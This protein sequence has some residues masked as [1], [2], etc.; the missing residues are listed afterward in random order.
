MVATVVPAVLLSIVYQTGVV[1][2]WWLEL[3]QYVPFPAFLLSAI[4]AFGLSFRL[5][6]AWRLAAAI[7]L[8]LVLTV[9]MGGVAGHADRGSGHV[10][11][12]TYNIKAWLAEHRNGGFSPLVWEVALQDPDILVMQ[13]AAELTEMREQA[14][15]TA[16]PIFKRR[17][18]FAF[19][20]YIVVSRFPLRDCQVGQIPY[21][22]EPHTYVRCIVTAQGVDIDLVTVHF[23]SPR[24]GLNAT[25]F[26]R[27]DGVGEWQ[28][29]FNDRLSQSSRLAADI[30]RRRRPLILAGDL[31]APESSPVVRH[32]LERGLRD[33]FSSAGWGYGYTHGHALKLRFSFLRIDHILVSPDI[34]VQDSFVGGKAASEHRPVI[35]DLWLQRE[36]D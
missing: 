14:P 9:L 22:G 32:L 30:S 29:N 16:S 4:V 3:L 35:A 6:R 31:N 20:Q 23:K 8:V 19:G 2:T 18:V 24:D 33:A 10:R 13:D 5:G 7:G 15:D 27:A 28:Q 1:S 25:R 36:P 17:Q 34:G 12:M 21:R 11:M 26:E